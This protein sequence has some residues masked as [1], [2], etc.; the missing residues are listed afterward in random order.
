MSLAHFEL[1]HVEELSNSAGHAVVVRNTFIEVEAAVEESY[2][3]APLRYRSSP[4]K[5]FAASVVKDDESGDES[6]EVA[7]QA[8]TLDPWSDVSELDFEALPRSRCESL[9]STGSEP[10]SP[11]MTVRWADIDDA[12]EDLD[13]APAP[14]QEQ[15][16]TASAGS[17]LH[18]LGECK[19]CAWFWKPQGC[20]WG[21]ECFYCHTCQASEL[22]KRKKAKAN[23]F[24]ATAASGSF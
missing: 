20:R 21:A 19:P 1:A 10:S 22:S 24:K 6:D 9:S 15:S 3:D 11:G 12:G 18:D 5:I 8:S 16:A 7:S 2:D 14:V 4:A 23:K 17:S 13:L